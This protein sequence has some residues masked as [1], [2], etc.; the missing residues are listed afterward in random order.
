MSGQSLA[1]AAYVTAP[2][3]TGTVS[4]TTV[5]L[6]EPMRIT[7]TGATSAANAVALPPGRMATMLV[8][9]VAI[10]ARW[11]ATA[12]TAAATDVYLPAGSRFRWY[13]EQSTQ[14]VAIEADGGSGTFEAHVWCSSTRGA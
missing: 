1:S 8:G 11:G 6:G 10:R 9:A 7:G 13:V 12:P 4:A 5:A 3:Y 14:F 2:V